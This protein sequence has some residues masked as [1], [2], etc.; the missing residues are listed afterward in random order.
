MSA[1][2]C[3]LSP[4]S[5]R[6]TPLWKALDDHQK[7][8]VEFG[9]ERLSVGYFAEQGTGKTWITVA[10]LD[11]IIPDHE[12]FEGYLVVPLTNK[13]TT[14]VKTISE[15]LPQVN[16]TSDWEEYKKLPFPRILLLHYEAFCKKRLVPKMQ[17]RSWHFGCFDESQRLKD[18]GSLGSRRAKQMSECTHR[19]VILSG[20][21]D[22]GAEEHYWAQFRYFAPFVFGT[23]WENFD[24]HY[25]KPTGFMGHKRKFKEHRRKEFQDKI[26]PWCLFISNEVLNRPSPKMTRVWVNMKGRQRRIYDELETT[27]VIDELDILTEFEMTKIIKLHQICG[28]TLL[29]E[30]WIYDVGVAKQRAC[31][32]I[33]DREDLPLVI[34]CRFVEEIDDLSNR[35]RE[36]GLRVK[37]IQGKNKKT[38]TEVQEQFQRGEIDVLVVQIRTGGVGIDLFRSHVCIV[39]SSTYSRIDFDQAIARLHRR[40]QEYEGPVRVYILICRDSVDEEILTAIIDKRS[41]S[42]TVLKYLKRRR[43]QMAKPKPAAKKVAKKK[44]PAK[45]KAAAKAKAPAAEAMKYG[46]DDL[47]AALGIKPA[48]ARVRLRNAGIEKAG[49]SYG[50]N[51]QKDLDAVVK[52]LKADDKEAA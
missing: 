48:S 40:G 49:K 15:Q 34:F 24:D 7:D 28:G 41:V 1:E 16:F 33:V 25:L 50:W 23:R 17:R 32:R 10:L 47:A 44:A 9:L 14:W 31:M 37:T 30:E 8:A 36:R 35:L 42:K 29:D 39:Y 18:R 46:V 12:N 22:D 6:E 4:R 43:R 19:K 26:R 38:R 2:S 21:P 3:L 45:A 20:T 13:E 27:M 51:S 52:S 5:A 11:Q